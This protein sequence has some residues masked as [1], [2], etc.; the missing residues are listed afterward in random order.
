MKEMLY[1]RYLVIADIIWSDRENYSVTFI[2][3][4]L[5]SGQ[6]VVDS[7]YNR[8]SFCQTVG[9]NQPLYSRIL[10]ICLKK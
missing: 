1:R 2:E 5:V 6:P 10:E 9:L 8:Q 7:R 4:P 3:K